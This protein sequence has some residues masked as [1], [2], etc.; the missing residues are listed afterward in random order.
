MTLVKQSLSTLQKDGQQ[1][2]EAKVIGKRLIRGLLQSRMRSSKQKI[3]KSVRGYKKELLV[4]PL[5]SLSLEL[6]LQLKLR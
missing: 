2:L 1:S 3:S 6:V 5:E 4:L